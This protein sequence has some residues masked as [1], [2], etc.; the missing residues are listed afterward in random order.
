MIVLDASA[1][2]DVVLDQPT[3]SWVL[4]QL[5]GTEVLAPAH[6]LA[7]VASAIAR[8]VRADQIRPDVGRDALVE[9]RAL[10]QEFVIPSEGHLL[11]ALALQDRIRV[12]D[13]LY[14]ALAEDH[15]ATLVTT[16]SRLGRAQLPVA[17]SLPSS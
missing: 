13:G 4:A 1:V 10:V 7:E 6:Q 9:A 8:L 17:V 15:H 12:P 16:D 3:K 5:A 2:V 14:V 11:R